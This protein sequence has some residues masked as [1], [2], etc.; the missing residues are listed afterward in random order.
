[1][2]T[3]E[4]IFFCRVPTA[5]GKAN[6]RHTRRYNTPT[7]ID[8]LSNLVRSLWRNEKSSLL[9]L[10]SRTAGAMKDGWLLTPLLLEVLA[11]S[12]W[13]SGT[14]FCFFPFHDLQFALDGV[15]AHELRGDGLRR[16]IGITEAR[17]R[18]KPQDLP[19]ST[20]AVLHLLICHGDVILG[21]G[22]EIARDIKE[23]EKAR[24]DLKQTMYLQGAVLILPEFMNKHAAYISLP[25]PIPCRPINHD[26]YTTAILSPC[27]IASFTPQ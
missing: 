23:I 26:T 24:W 22:E 13:H 12:L 9:P 17:V 16:V 2:S 1:M 20:K 18:R 5:S 25:D 27:L 8:A 3:K 7:P 11:A 21:A 10:Y 14:V 15:Q 6:D 4:R 19:H